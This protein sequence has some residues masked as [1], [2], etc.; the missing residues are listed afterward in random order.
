MPTPHPI[1]SQRFSA[2][3]YRPSARRCGHRRSIALRFVGR[4]LGLVGVL[5]LAC[6][7]AACDP[8]SLR[9]KKKVEPAAVEPTA[10]PTPRPKPKPDDATRLDVAPEAEPE[11]TPNPTASPSKTAPPIAPAEPLKYGIPVPGNPGYVTSP[12]APN[13]GWV[14]V[15]GFPP[16]YEVKDPYTDKTFLVP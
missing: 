12:Y 3:V 15:R 9:K 10:E 11:V 16:S 1:L 4:F 13:S 8:D 14:D 6:C 2:A 7:F 5:S